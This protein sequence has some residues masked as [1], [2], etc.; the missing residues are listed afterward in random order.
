[1]TTYTNNLD[2]DVDKNLH[3]NVDKLFEMPE[4]FDI[5]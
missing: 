2:D 5:R 1:M 3:D 4:K